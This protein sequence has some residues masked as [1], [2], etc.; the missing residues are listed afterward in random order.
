MT[1]A[2]KLANAV[3]NLQMLW[4]SG[5]GLVAI[6]FLATVVFHKSGFVHVVLVVGICCYLIQFFQDWRTRE[7]RK[8]L[9]R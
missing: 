7:Y 1:F 8:S 9:D 2:H 6:W 3:R 4:I 5:T